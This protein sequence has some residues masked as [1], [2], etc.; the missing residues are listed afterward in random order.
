[1]P[2]KEKYKNLNSDQEEKKRIYEER[3]KVYQ[4]LP[5]KQ[6]MTP[7]MEKHT[8][9]VDYLQELRS[10]RTNESNTYRRPKCKI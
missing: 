6:A 10:K 9:S 8:A 2:A 7:R 3:M 4:S 5:P 1:M